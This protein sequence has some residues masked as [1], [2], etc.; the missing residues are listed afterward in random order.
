VTEIKKEGLRMSICGSRSGQC[1]SKTVNSKNGK[2]KMKRQERKWYA[3]LK[4]MKN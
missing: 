1:K 4:L 3:S 2:G